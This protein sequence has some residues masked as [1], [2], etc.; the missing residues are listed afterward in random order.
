MKR[1]THF[2]VLKNTHLPRERGNLYKGVVGQVFEDLQKIDLEEV[3][4][5]P[6]AA[7]PRGNYE[8]F[9]SMVHREAN[10]RGVPRPA[11]SF[12]KKKQVF[13]L[14]KVAGPGNAVLAQGENSDLDFHPVEIRGEPLSSTI[15]R[16][17]R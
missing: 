4:A 10:R 6:I 11:T 14:K 7:I 3:L 1:R 16:E 5:I 12:D 8:T 2:R 13:Y 15:L 9:R 17:R